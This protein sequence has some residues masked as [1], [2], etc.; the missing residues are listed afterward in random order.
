MGSKH[1][2]GFRHAI[3]LWLLDAPVGKVSSFEIKYHHLLG[4][5]VRVSV[6]GSRCSTAIVSHEKPFHR[7]ASNGAARVAADLTAA[8]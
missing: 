8:P 7:H 5:M 1:G 6:K 2:H 4:L 3:V